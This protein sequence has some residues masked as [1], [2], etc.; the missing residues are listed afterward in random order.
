MICSK[1]VPKPMMTKILCVPMQGYAE[2]A[3]L[4]HLAHRNQECLQLLWLW[5]QCPHIFEIHEWQYNRSDPRKVTNVPIFF[6]G[7]G[8][9]SPFL[10]SLGRAL[11]WHDYSLVSPQL[12]YTLTPRQNDSRS[13]DIF[14]NE[15]VWIFRL[16]FHW[17]LFPGVKLTIFQHWFR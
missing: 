5:G 7:M 16:I 2:A 17:N 11:Q 3:F 9:L 10:Q 8:H 13:K 14:L 6:N 15:N 12:V 1:S 4:G